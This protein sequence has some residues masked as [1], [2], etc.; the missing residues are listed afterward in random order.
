M[1]KLYNKLKVKF[2]FWKKFGIEKNSVTGIT[3][4]GGKT[5]LMFGLAEELSKQGKVLVTTTTKIYEPDENIYEE[6][7]LTENKKFFRG[8]GKNIF[9]L[10]L[11]IE[12]G[13]LFS[14]KEEDILKIKSQYDYILYEGDGSKQKFMK[15]WREDEPCLLSFT[16]TVIGVGNIKSL[17]LPFNEENVHRYNVY[18][19]KNNKFYEKKYIDFEILKSYLTE[20]KF[21]RN[22]EGKKIIFLNGVENFEEIKTALKLQKK[23]KNF[24]FG[25][26]KKKE[27]YMDNNISA[28]VMGSGKSERF[29]KNKLLEKID[30]VPMIEILLKK[31][32][33]L[34][35]K[36]IFVTYKDKEI[37]EICKKYK[38]I[39]LENKKYFLGQ[40]ESIKLGTE[41]IKDENIMFFTGDMPFLKEETIFKIISEFD[42][43]ITIPVVNGKR[44]S[45]VIFP[46]KY[47]EELLSLSGDV[48]G[49]EIIKKEKKLNFIEFF[50]KKQFM[51]IDRKED[52]KAVIKNDGK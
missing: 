14:P 38:V 42:G 26:V 27:M 24:T 46:N 45:P 11:K 50:D 40:S 52:L 29:G 19:D 9:I 10:G 13:K 17:G 32:K 34:P 1:M 16:D 3:G 33:E 4:S 23:I 8:K 25:S 7:F 37:F 43:R 6:L 31:L 20:G 30:G 47:K 36:N 28:V 15:F 51:D 49:R 41:N 21:F 39:P 44:C 2:L 35:F 22:F 5:S 12:N 18:M 48:G